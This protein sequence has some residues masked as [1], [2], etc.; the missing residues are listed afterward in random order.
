M[1][2]DLTPEE[3]AEKLALTLK[4]NELW[5]LGYTV[6]W[7]GII[8]QFLGKLVL[9][10]MYGWHDWHV[11]VLASADNSRP[12]PALLERPWRRQRNAHRG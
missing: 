7:K 6:R 3:R 4:C 1:D 9:G 8:I 5:A 2:D 10:G 11:G 12:A